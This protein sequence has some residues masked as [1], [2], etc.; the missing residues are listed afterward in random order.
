MRWLHAFLEESD[1][2]AVRRHHRRC[3]KELVVR[4]SSGRNSADGTADVPSRPTGS[5]RSRSRA[6]RPRKPKG[7]GGG[8]GGGGG[9]AILP[10][11]RNRKCPLYKL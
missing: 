4:M 7:R 1:T 11:S 10:G 3:A 6:R 8:G 5:R 9:G 2:A